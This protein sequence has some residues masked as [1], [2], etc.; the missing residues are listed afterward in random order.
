MSKGKS[1]QN[2]KR[3]NWKALE[4]KIGVHSSHFL[5]VGRTDHIN[6]YKNLPTRMYLYVD[7]AGGCYARGPHEFELANLEEEWRKI[8][9]NPSGFCHSLSAGDFG[10]LGFICRQL[11]SSAQETF[12][13]V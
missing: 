5:Y 11:A 9:E 4:E 2:N 13:V 6:I 7:D 1:P 3:S 8:A 12:Q 10:S